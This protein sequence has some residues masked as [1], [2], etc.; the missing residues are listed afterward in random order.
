MDDQPRFSVYVIE[1]DERWW[2][3]VG[4]AG[5][6]TTQVLY[7][8]STDKA[9]E[10]RAAEHLE[11]V[12][13]PGRIG[14]NSARV[15]KR[16]R[17]AREQGGLMGPLEPGDDARLRADLVEHF[18]TRAEARAREGSLARQLGRRRGVVALSDRARTRRRKRPAT[19]T[20]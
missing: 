16:I 6:G 13:E 5:E 14:R 17:T 8:G 3:L 18:P 4:R 9:P 7:V 15:F 1:I 10:Q 2:Q 12:I 11:G 19:S 20:R